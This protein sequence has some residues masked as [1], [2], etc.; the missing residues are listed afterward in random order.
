MLVALAKG[1]TVTTQAGGI[2]TPWALV[3]VLAA[4]KMRRC[5]VA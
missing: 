2:D 1:E 5:W 3:E 4:V